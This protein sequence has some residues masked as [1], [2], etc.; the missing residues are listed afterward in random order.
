MNSKESTKALILGTYVAMIV[1]LAEIFMEVVDFIGGGKETFL[2]PQ[3]TT[4]GFLFVVFT[5]FKLKIDNK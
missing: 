4:L 3:L 1:I 2:W 5:Y